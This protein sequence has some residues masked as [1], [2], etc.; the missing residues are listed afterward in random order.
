MIKA[1]VQ[2]KS[3][4]FLMSV[5]GHLVLIAVMTLSFSLVVNHAKM[6]TP[7]RVQITEIDLRNI[8]E[9]LQIRG[10]NKVWLIRLP[11]STALPPG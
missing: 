7:N 10:G 2:F 6:V 8:W 3:E 1:D 11:R 4:N 9:K 5:F